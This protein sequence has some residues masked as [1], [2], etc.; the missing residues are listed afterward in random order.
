MVGGGEEGEKDGECTGNEG[1]GRMREEKYVS[2]MCMCCVC[3]CG[4][5]LFQATT[6]FYRKFSR[7]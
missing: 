5:A 3:V 1:G 4:I 2:S 7:L 6:I